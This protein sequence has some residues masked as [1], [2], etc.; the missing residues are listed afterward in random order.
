MNDLTKF[1]H[2]VFLSRESI[3][4]RINDSRETI[5]FIA[6]HNFKAFAIM[7]ERAPFKKYLYVGKKADGMSIKIPRPA[8]KPHWWPKKRE[9]KFITVDWLLSMLLQSESKHAEFI[10]E[11]FIQEF[12]LNLLSLEASISEAKLD[13]LEVER[14]IK[15]ANCK[16]RYWS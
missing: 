7:I 8:G 2:G 16:D 3:S 9:M 5:N 6:V 13:K 14:L 15:I 4:W 11:A 12:S 10:H 1:K